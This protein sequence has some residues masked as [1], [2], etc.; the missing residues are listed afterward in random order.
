M[1]ASLAALCLRAPAGPPE[2]GQPSRVG[3]RKK[4][5]KAMARLFSLRETLGSHALQRS[6]EGSDVLPQPADRLGK[7][8]P[9]LTPTSFAFV[10][11]EPA[12]LAA[13]GRMGRV[14]L[15]PSPRPG[16]HARDDDEH[17]S[18]GS[19]RTLAARRFEEA[20]DMCHG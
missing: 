13:P 12:G 9:L 11:P 1:S 8:S 4:G 15:G 7:A 20:G 2:G 18:A 3:A 16:P 17:G 14:S 19:W 5:R 10:G 6:E